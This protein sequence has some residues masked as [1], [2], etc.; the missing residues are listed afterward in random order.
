MIGREDEVREYRDRLG[1]LNA[2]LGIAFTI[3]VSRLVYLQ[4][5][6]GDEL[7]AF[8][9]TNRLKKEKLFPPRGIIFDRYGKVIVDNRASFDVVLLP[10]YYLSALKR[11]Q[12]K[13]ATT[14]LRERNKRIAKALQMPLEEIEERIE[15]IAGA[16]KYIPIVLKADA[17][18][19]VI[20][21]VETD[22]EG[23]PG[24][25]IV[26][27][28]LR[29]YPYKDMAAQVL[30]YISEVN[31]NEI[32]AAAKGGGKRKLQMGDYIGK[33]GLER[34]YDTHLRGENGF[35]YVEVDARGRRRRTEGGERLLSFVAETDPVPGRNIYLTIDVD[36]EL[37]A[38][39]ALRS[40]KFNGALVALDPR[41][42]EILA[43][44]SEPSFNPGDLSKREIDND[45]WKKVMTDPDKPLLNR[46]MQGAY[47]PGS[48]F[49]LFMAVAALSEKTTSK[50]FS[51]DCVGSFRFGN[52]AFS[53]WKTHH[54]VELV[55]S[56]RESCDVFYYNVGAKIGIDKIAE[57][58]R[59]FGL[60]RKTEM[61][62]G[63]ESGGLFPE[64]SGLIPDSAWKESVFKQPWHPGETISVSIGQ[65]YVTVTPIQMAAAYAAIGNG[66]FLYRPYLVRKIE[67]RGGEVLQEFRPELRS[68]IDVP[69]EVFEGVKDGLFQVVNHPKGTAYW[70][71]RSKHVA[72]SGKTGTAQVR[73]FT[74]IMRL[75]CENMPI[76]DRHH[77]WFAGYAPKENP[78]IAIAVITEHG[79]HGT[80]GAAVV[81][82]V[83]E[84]YVKKKYA[85]EGKE[86]PVIKEEKP[87]RPPP[88]ETEDEG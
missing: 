37:A 41:S 72:I 77:G 52:R 74:N 60:G 86:L 71:G 83:I 85:L 51:V 30:G 57:Y 15:D 87:V 53:C 40:R 33:I 28:V 7:R 70:M 21:A 56:I 23:F 62:K 3:L 58:A 1:F 17:S 63:F 47:P 10:Q 13:E 25:D 31:P 34:I 42:G 65:G 67:G 26:S 61:G 39:E 66:G 27:N 24:I 35:G 2:I 64:V 80:A 18:K 8:S 81:K 32:K 9:E 76:K 14:L 4:V 68:K 29:R 5:L 50:N 54:Y 43:M 45:V 59:K 6:K 12:W 11:S 55:K 75:K 88:E 38:Q 49:K 84:A 79:C 73:S 69:P 82:D 46:P 22:T 44:V 78:E 16:P 19:D 48:T 36:L 20:A